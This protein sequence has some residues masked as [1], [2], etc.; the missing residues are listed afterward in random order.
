MACW[1]D[2]IDETR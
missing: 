1:I 2:E